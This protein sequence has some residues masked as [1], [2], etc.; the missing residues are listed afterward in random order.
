MDSEQLLYEVNELNH[1]F[2]DSTTIETLL[3]KAVEMVAARTHSA[4]CSIYLYS[5]EERVLT[6]RATRGLNPESVGKVRLR[7]G[8]GLTGLA[9][10]EMKTICEK[11]ASQNPNYR[12]FPGIFEERFDAFLALPIAR[13]ISKMG[14]L[15]LQR[16]TGESFIEADIRALE[17]VASQLANIIENAQFLLGMHEPRP[18]RP[19][20]EPLPAAQMKLIKGKVAAEGFAYAPA[21]VIDKQ[22]SLSFLLDRRFEGQYS[23]DDFHEAVA[24]TAAQLEELQERVES[25]LSDA[26]SLIF[27]AHLMILKDKAFIDE[28]ARRIESG[29]NP[30]V[31]VAEVSGRFVQTFL[32]S[33]NAYMREKV[34]DIEDMAIRLVNNLIHAGEDTRIYRGHVII[35][36]DLYPSDLLK[37]SSE[38][39]C[40]VVLVGG[41]VTSHIAILARSLAIPMVIVDHFDLLSLPN[42]TP[43]LIDAEIGN[44]FVDPEDQVLDTFHSQQRVRLT[45]DEQAKRIQ[46]QTLTADAVP[47]RLL[48]NINLLTDLAL[49]A[50]L[51]CNG[52][53]LYRTEFPFIVRTTFPSEAEQFV[54]YSKVVDSMQGKPVTFRTLDA[55]GDKILSYYHDIQEQN[56]AMGMRSIRFSLQNRAIFSEQIRAI[57]RAGVDADLRIMFPMI[58]SVDEFCRA[59]EVVLE[60][61][62]TLARQ[63]VAHNDRPKL[64]MMVELPSVVELIDDLAREAEFFSIGT[65]DFIQFMLGVDRTND[66]VAD[67][68]LPHHPSV[69]RALNKIVRAANQSGREVSVCGDMA[70]EQQYIPFLLGIGVRTLSVDPAYLLRTQ[71]TIAGTSVPKAEATAQ[72]MLA[73]NRTDEIVAI[74][75]AQ[76]AVD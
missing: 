49:A 11:D 30:P 1:L 59:R 39:A 50:K 10:K 27:A 63:G 22:K 58:S 73:R 53:G 40:G 32:A 17:T 21:M 41:G 67:F 29:V 56:P 66:S 45:V 68:Y 4:V 3:D 35:T 43:I 7:L 64:G 28:I 38:E 5:P 8:Q 75:S 20:A 57:L 76:P 52:V 23:L 47:I 12:F 69:L 55:G 46:P 60:S 26:A 42:G 18:K 48:A 44:V 31:A 34:N 13:G 72:A 36:R 24:R 15:V 51:K 54:I 2:R 6:L 16:G 19:P 65:N 33:D 9:L 37:L 74:L 71:Q 62:D 61:L 70:H 14:V 25:K